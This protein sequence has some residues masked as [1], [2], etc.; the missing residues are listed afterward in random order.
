MSSVQ[1]PGH[2]TFVG[3]GPGHPDLLTLGA[4]SALA[5]ADVVLH[6]RLV[7]DDILVLIRTGA[8]VLSVG[9]EGFGP[10]VTQSEINALL[11]GF[12]LKGTPVIRLKSG[13]CGVFGRLDD[14]IAALDALGIGWTILPGITSAAAAAASIGQSLTQR[15]RNRSLR[16]L[17]GHDVDGFAEHDWRALSEPGAVAAIYM[18]KRAT[19]FLQGRLMMH[20]ADVATPVTIVENVS[21]PDQRV[22]AATIATLPAMAE[23]LAGPSVILLG[24]AP[25][26]AAGVLRKLKE[27]AG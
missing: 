27:V 13:D 15:G 1:L 23:R 21:R 7:G 8:T 18:G 4:A 17:T 2:V 6:D 5:A 19:R 22:M 26:A 9:K 3:A 16:F 11:I 10:S 25:R 20:G 14:E 24:L 12:A